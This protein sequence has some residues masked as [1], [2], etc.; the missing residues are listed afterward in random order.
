MNATFATSETGLLAPELDPPLS[1]PA[2]PK[3]PEAAGAIDHRRPGDAANEGVEGSPTT[4]KTDETDPDTPTAKIAAV[5]APDAR[6]VVQIHTGRMH[7]TYAEAEEQ[8]SAQGT[9]FERSGFIVRVHR[10]SLTGNCSIREVSAVELT[11]TLDQVSAWQRFDKRA[12]DWVPTDPPPRVC[13][14]LAA[15]RRTD[16]LR[17]LAGLARQPHLRTRFVVCRARL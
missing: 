15:A 5:N 8:L 10:D 2:I 9:H 13:T 12:N 1:V 4:A 14:V 17:P 7:L 16:S 6:P 11:R 3:L